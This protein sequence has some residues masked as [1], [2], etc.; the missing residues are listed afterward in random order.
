MKEI[1]PLD[2]SILALLAQ[3]PKGVEAARQSLFEE[4]QKSLLHRLSP[5]AREIGEAILA[6]E[7][8]VRS[9]SSAAQETAT[10]MKR[11][12]VANNAR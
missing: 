3:V 1:S 9:F 10:E 8:S 6:E 5:E 12:A 7:K 11:W 2:A 4:T